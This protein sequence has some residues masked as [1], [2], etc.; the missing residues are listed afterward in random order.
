MEMEPCDPGPERAMRQYLTQLLETGTSRST[1]CLDRFVKK[2]MSNF[3]PPSSLEGKAS[4]CSLF[5]Q[6]LS[7]GSRKS[8]RLLVPDLATEWFRK[9]KVFLD[10]LSPEELAALSDGL[11]DKDSKKSGQ[12][13][14]SSS[15]PCRQQQQAS[16][17]EHQVQWLAK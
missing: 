10:K 1:G 5:E 4:R 2:G 7:G 9:Q 13:Q 14:S 6:L 15:T 12:K 16:K 11:A 3:P 17:S 8:E